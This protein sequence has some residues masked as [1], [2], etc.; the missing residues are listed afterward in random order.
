MSLPNTTGPATCGSWKA[1]SN[2]RLSPVRGTLFKVLDRFETFRKVDEQDVKVLADLERDHILKVLQRTGWRIEGKCGAALL[3][4]LNPS[5]LR[6]RMRK[7]GIRR[8]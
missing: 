7:Y 4:G 2:E 5:T 1:S 6:A 8:K 3:L